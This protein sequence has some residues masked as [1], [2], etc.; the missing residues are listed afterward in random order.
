M[1]FVS[2]KSQHTKLTFKVYDFFRELY[3]VKSDVEV[4]HT[5]LTDDNAFGFTE[6]NGDEQFIQIHNDLSEKD[7]ITTLCHE[8]V[9]VMQ[10]EN[11]I[12]DDKIREDEAYAFEDILYNQYL[13]SV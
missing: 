7:F 1:L 3:D 13:Q 6:E 5:D 4:F 11:G 9:H 8:L 2:G 12:T 10:N